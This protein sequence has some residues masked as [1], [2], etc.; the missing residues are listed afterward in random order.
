[1]NIF[2]LENSLQEKLNVNENA[3]GP[4]V[5]IMVFVAIFSIIAL[6]VSYASDDDQTTIAAFAIS[7]MVDL[8]LASLFFI[9][10]WI[11]LGI[12][13]FLGLSWLG[14]NWWRI[15]DLV[16]EWGKKKDVSAN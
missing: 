9:N 10:I 3:I 2:I 1:M 7:L 15:E 5:L 14:Y 11:N 13:T 12:I 4:I 6:F 16:K 8:L